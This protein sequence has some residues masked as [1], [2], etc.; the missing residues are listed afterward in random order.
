METRS[1]L[2][3]MTAT[4]HFAL[5]ASGCITLAAVVLVALSW[6]SAL[7]AAGPGLHKT[8][9]TLGWVL[10]A[11][12]ISQIVLGI[13]VHFVSGRRRQALGEPEPARSLFQG[14]VGVV[15][16]VLLPGVHSPR[17]SPS[18]R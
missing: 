13:L 12:V 8:Y 3:L 1:R 7:F 10:G 9:D 14:A 15:M 5:V 4:L 17:H 11:G 18:G 2:R 16:V 6:R